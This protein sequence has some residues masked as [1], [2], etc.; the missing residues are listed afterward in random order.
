MK[1]AVLIGSLQAESINR[2]LAKNLKALAP[3]D[4]EFIYLDIDLPPFNQG[5]ED[6]LPV[7]VSALKTAIE[8]ADGV[9]VV[10]PEYNRSIP[11][12]L[13]NA[14]DWASRPYGSNSFNEKP[15]GIIGASFGS[16]GTAQAQAQ[17]RNVFIYL[18]TKLMGQPE[19]YISAERTFDEAGSVKEDS[20]EFLQDYIDAFIK[21][22]EASRG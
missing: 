3:E 10:T 13:K 20:K 11:G 4:V 2:V 15:T 6:K 17:L 16:T 12:V 22:V 8:T 9:L 14:I 18:N 1:I 5:L 21:H 19:L 7:K